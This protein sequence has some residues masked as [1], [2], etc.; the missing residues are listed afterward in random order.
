[1]SAS[2][3]FAVDGV[4]VVNGAISEF[5]SIGDMLVIKVTIFYFN[6][7]CSFISSSILTFKEIGRV[8]DCFED[9]IVF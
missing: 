4:V 9:N 1:M 2:N 7:A 5:C 8:D 6:S 3:D